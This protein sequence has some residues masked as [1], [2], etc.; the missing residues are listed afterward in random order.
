[1]QKSL[2][3][4]FSI[5]KEQMRADTKEI[6]RL[7]EGS[8]EDLL[9]SFFSLCKTNDGKFKSEK[10]GAFLK[11]QAEDGVFFISQNLSF[12]TS[13]QSQRK[14]EWTV[15]LDDEGV[16]KIVKRTGSKGDE[17]YWA[18]GD[19]NTI[20]GKNNLAQEKNS[21]IMQDEMRG[22]LVVWEKELEA[23]QTEAQKARD[24]L[25]SDDP[26]MADLKASV[27]DMVRKNLAG[28]EDDIARLQAA[29]DRAKAQ[30]K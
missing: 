21:G 17:V 19:A 18:R 29:I 30:L 16:T 6:R 8:R 14:V 27:G 22:H 11:A 3:E 23:K 26:A 20:A 24:F 28:Q 15:T 7:T 2:K 10:Q 12:G 9:R 5:V 1:M 13:S 4:I 25:A